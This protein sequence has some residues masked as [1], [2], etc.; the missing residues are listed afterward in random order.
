MII[1]FKNEYY[2]LSK[3]CTKIIKKFKTLSS[4]NKYINKNIKII[5]FKNEYYAVD[6]KC[7]KILGKYKTFN[8]AYK[9][10][11][12]IEYFKHL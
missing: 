5:K 8:D 4:A 9:R 11:R 1:K 3:T 10:L 6:N 7:Q 12:Q 2:I